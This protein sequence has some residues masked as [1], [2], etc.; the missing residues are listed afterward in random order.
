MRSRL[1][2]AVASGLL[3]GLGA[4][5]LGAPPATGVLLGL[6]D[7]ALRPLFR[8]LYDGYCANAERRAAEREEAARQEALSDGD[9]I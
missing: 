2:P 4:A 6:A 3:V 1:A 7:A 8:S 9:G 5:I